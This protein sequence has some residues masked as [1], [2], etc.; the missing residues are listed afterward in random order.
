MTVLHLDLRPTFVSDNGFVIYTFLAILI[1]RCREMLL[2]EDRL[3]AFNILFLYEY[4]C[5]CMG[6]V[7]EAC[8][9]NTLT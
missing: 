4:F 8:A 5:E 6:F 3:A 7:P 2:A 9:I 1:P